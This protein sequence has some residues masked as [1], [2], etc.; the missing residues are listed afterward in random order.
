MTG[1]EA[2]PRKGWS[3]FY[4]AGLGWLLL[5][6]WAFWAYYS[7]SAP[8]DTPGIPVSQLVLAVIFFWIGWRRARAKG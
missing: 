8:F 1:E 2:G 7:G 6:A 3:L 4:V 5:A